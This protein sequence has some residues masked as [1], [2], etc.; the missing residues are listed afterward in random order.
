MTTHRRYETLAEIYVHVHLGALHVALC[1]GHNLVTIDLFTPDLLLVTAS[2]PVESHSLINDRLGIAPIFRAEDNSHILYHLLSTLRVVILKARVENLC[3]L[4]VFGL[5][6]QIPVVAELLFLGFLVLGTQVLDHALGIVFKCAV[7]LL[8]IELKLYFIRICR[9]LL[10]VDRNLSHFD[11][12]LLFI[13][14][15]LLG[16]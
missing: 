16:E 9:L 3:L 1:N 5:L 12:R 10:G 7:S 4:F 6:V 15:L 8:D 2:T 14:L 11:P 13:R